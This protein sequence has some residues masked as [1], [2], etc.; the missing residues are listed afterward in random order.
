MKII[1][2]NFEPI[3]C[4]L[5]SLEV[6][7]NY[8][9]IEIDVVFLNICWV[10]T[11]LFT[12][13]YMRILLHWFTYYLDFIPLIQKTTKEQQQTLKNGCSVVLIFPFFPDYSS[14][15][16]LLVAG[17]TSHE[18][19]ET[20]PFL[21]L[22]SEWGCKFTSFSNAMCNEMQCNAT[23]RSRIWFVDLFFFSFC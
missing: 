4:L 9:N 10:N 15:F 2:L 8:P 16:C 23:N 7:D 1:E 13:I 19:V 11:I 17:F 22:I 6:I 5:T 21:V 3:T 20:R 14:I 12:I 18:S